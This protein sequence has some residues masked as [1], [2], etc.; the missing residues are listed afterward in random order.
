MIGQPPTVAIRDALDN[1]AADIATL[2]DWTYTDRI[3]TR[4]DWRR[5]RA[6]LVFIDYAPATECDRDGS[7]CHAT[8]LQWEWRLEA[9]AERCAPG[10]YV[11]STPIDT[12]ACP[13]A[14]TAMSW[15]WPASKRWTP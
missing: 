7:H 6:T 11:V 9:V 15:T 8:T 2:N 10:D 3:N 13:G 1:A 12:N 14:V 4:G 5:I